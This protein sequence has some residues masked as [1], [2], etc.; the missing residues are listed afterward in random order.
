MNQTNQTINV[1]NTWRLH[2]LPAI[3]M[4]FCIGLTLYKT[5]S[6]GISLTMGLSAFGIY[7][8]T[9]G[10]ALMNGEVIKGTRARNIGTIFIGLAFSIL[11]IL[12]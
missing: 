11:T 2:Y 5:S 6:M 9:I 3:I 10:E 4:I 7:T 8:V 12:T 1:S